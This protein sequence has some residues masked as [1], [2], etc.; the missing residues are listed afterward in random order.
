MAGVQHGFNA[1]LV[2]LGSMHAS[3]LQC[4]CGQDLPLTVHS[5]ELLRGDSGAGHPC[6][7]LTSRACWG[8]PLP[9][10]VA[11]VL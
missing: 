11:I 10:G 2:V 3:D 4:I 6:Q 9:K 8:Q 1:G 5:G 7:I